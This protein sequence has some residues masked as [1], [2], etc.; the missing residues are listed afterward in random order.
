[1]TEWDFLAEL[2]QRS[3]CGILLD[4]NNIYVSACNHGFDARRY[5]RAIPAGPVGEIHLAG[6]DRRTACSSTP[7]ARACATKSGRCTARRSALRA[8]AD[9]DRMGHRPAGASTVLLEEA[10]TAQAILEECHALAG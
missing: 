2:A 6:F 7:T 1:M 9:P 10:A 4:V 5:L 3:G 8:G